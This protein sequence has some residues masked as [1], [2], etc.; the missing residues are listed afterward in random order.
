M[1]AYVQNDPIFLVDVLGLHDTGPCPCGP[2][3]TR[4]VGSIMMQVRQTFNTW[5]PIQQKIACMALTGINGFDIDHLVLKGYPKLTGEDKQYDECENTYTFKDHCYYAGSIN[6]I[7]Y[8]RARQLCQ[9]EITTGGELA[10][11]TMVVAYKNAAHGFLG[12]LPGQQFQAPPPALR[13]AIV[14]QAVAF[15]LFGYNPT[16]DA[17]LAQTC[18][19]NCK[20]NTTPLYFG[21]ASSGWKWKPYK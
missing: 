10:T 20:V 7:L 1:Y 12:L 18:L 14:L 9:G 4:Q 8:G 17:E 11:T 16:R 21:I 3:V 19:K 13:D 6:Y 15:A 5:T 2:D